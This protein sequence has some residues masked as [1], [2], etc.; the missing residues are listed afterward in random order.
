VDY[1][2]GGVTV[3]ECRSASTSSTLKRYSSRPTTFIK[4]SRCSGRKFRRRVKRKPVTRSPRVRFLF[5]VGCNNISYIL[6]VDT[7]CGSCDALDVTVVG[8]LAVAQT[9]FANCDIQS[10]TTATILATY[11]WLTQFV[12]V[13]M[14]WMSQLANPVCATA[15]VPTTVTSKASQLQ[16]Y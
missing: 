10:I 9:G 8:T 7:V 5:R 16:Q 15:K 11:F 1:W 4:I 14:L 2:W 3:C 13:V 6:L 12:A